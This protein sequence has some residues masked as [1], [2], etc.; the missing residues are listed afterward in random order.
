MSELR[1]DI[2][3][4]AFFNLYM[5]ERVAADDIDDFVGRWH[6]EF[7]G[8]SVYPP[9]HE[10]LGLTHLEYEILM[11]DPFALPLIRQARQ[12]GQDLVDLMAERFDQLSA[13][14]RRED[15]TIIFSLGHWLKRLGRR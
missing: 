4:P 13:A 1:A 8:K 10:Y 2:A 12:T 3:T 15:G 7:E 14:N 9:L 11:Y 6:D 5:Q